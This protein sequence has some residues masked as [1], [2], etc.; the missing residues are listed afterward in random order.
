[1]E[2]LERA[3]RLDLGDPMPFAYETDESAKLYQRCVELGANP[4]STVAWPDRLR[5]AFIDSRKPKKTFLKPI[6]GR[7][8]RKT[9]PVRSR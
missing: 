5:K 4:I 3:L 9:P 7:L 8:S 2:I 1:M 6:R